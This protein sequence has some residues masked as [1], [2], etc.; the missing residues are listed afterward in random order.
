[1]NFRLHF[2]FPKLFTK[3]RK[4]K[5]IFPY[6]RA[7]LEKRT[8]SAEGDGMVVKGISKRVI[9]VKSPDPKIFEQA[10][11]IIRE[12]YCGASG[13]NEQDVLREAK[14]AANGYFLSVGKQ[15]RGNM[16]QKLRGLFCALAGAA[17]AA[18]AWMTYH[19]IVF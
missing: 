12:D 5:N 19:F 6:R 1:M 2:S 10:I 16:L 13:M 14:R 18:A 3:C 7:S 11:F 17:A 8:Y 15:R 9:V 4:E